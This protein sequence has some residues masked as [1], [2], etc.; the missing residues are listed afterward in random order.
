MPSPEK[1]VPHNI[2]AEEAVLGALL[3]DPGCAPELG[4]L[5]TAEDFY[6]QKHRWIFSAARDLA[7][8]GDPLD[9]LTLATALEQRGQLEAVGGAVYLSQLINA[10]P[11]AIQ[12]PYYARLIIE[13]RK[14]RDMLDMVSEVARVAY[15][16]QMTLAE[17][18][19]Y[20][21]ER[22]NRIMAQ[23]EGTQQYQSF[24][25]LADKLPPVQWLWPGWI[26]RGMLTLLGA[27]PGAGKSLMALD[28]A[29]RVINGEH[30]PDGARNPCGEQPVIYVDAE[31]VP[32][33]LRERALGW[34]IPLDHLYLMM[35]NPNDMIDFGRP[36]YKDK[37]RNMVF[38]IKPGL[39]IIDSLSS[40]TSKGENS[41]ED[42][43]GIMGFLNEVVNNHQTSILIVHHLR[44]RGGGMQASLPGFSDLS[45]DD[46]RGSSHIIAMSRS[47]LGLSVVQTEAEPNRNGPRK[48]EVIKTNLA[49]YPDP[50]GCELLPMHPTGVMI[51]YTNEAPQEYRAP[52][53]VDQCAEWLAALLQDGGPLSPKECV[54]LAREEG[55]SQAT[56]Y[57]ARKTI[58]RVIDTEGRQSPSNKWQWE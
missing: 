40:V 9:F 2:E 37:L 49:A 14:R 28:L 32:Q 16:E 31:M 51:R 44:K 6:L 26:P 27:V 15:N 3:I 23:T 25:I 53:K 43:R 21:Q 13:T 41:V 18:S 54:E 56:V 22:M 47:V 35:P 39:V 5:L 24:A 4:A 50:L 55:F 1:T 7:R 42:I 10:V 8:N 58:N 19:S 33:L 29:K 17:A 11:S 20:V 45:I 36:E 12:A 34:K 38:Q 48:L 30:F 46:F 52:S 57:R